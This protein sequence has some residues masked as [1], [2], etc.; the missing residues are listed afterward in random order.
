MKEN[1]PRGKVTTYCV[2]ARALRSSPRAV[3]QALKK[4]PYA[5]KVPCHR[6]VMSD[7]S[8]GGFHG[9]TTGPE[10]ERKKSLLESEG[11]RIREGK[12]LKDCLI[13]TR[14]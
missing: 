12:V 3:G 4:N 7:G 11:V 8:I 2:I 10:I 14:N 6:V 13:T 1:V 9:Q 5:P